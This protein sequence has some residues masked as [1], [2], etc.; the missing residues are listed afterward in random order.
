MTTH[1]TILPAAVADQQGEIAG[2]CCPRPTQ[3]APLSEREL[4]GVAAL[5]IE[6]LV[7][8]NRPTEQRK[9]GRRSPA[10]AEFREAATA[11]HQCVLEPH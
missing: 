7:A 3:S 6:R 2:P 11:I 9:T 4:R 8:A 10:N 1:C 5:V